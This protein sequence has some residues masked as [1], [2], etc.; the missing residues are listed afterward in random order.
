MIC[1]LVVLTLYNSKDLVGRSPILSGLGIISP[2]KVGC[3]WKKIVYLFL[4]ESVYVS[5]PEAAAITYESGQL[6]IKTIIT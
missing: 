2:T 3:S 4:D 5:P 6:H 1:A